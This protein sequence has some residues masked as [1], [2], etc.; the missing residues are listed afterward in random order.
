MIPWRMRSVFESHRPSATN[1]APQLG[2]LQRPSFHCTTVE[3]V[4][5]EWNLV[6]EMLVEI[7]ALG[8][9]AARRST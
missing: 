9:A 2:R 1:E 6:V 8:R 3:I 4:F 7:A 5:L